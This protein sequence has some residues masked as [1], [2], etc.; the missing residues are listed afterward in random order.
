M[1]VNLITIILATVWGTY[2]NHK[3]LLDDPSSLL[4][5]DKFKPIFGTIP[6]TMNHVEIQEGDFSA[7]LAS[8]ITEVLRAKAKD[9]KTLEG[10]TQ[11]DSSSSESRGQCGLYCRPFSGGE[12][13]EDLNKNTYP[14]QVLKGKLSISPL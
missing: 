6:L 2:E 11:L 9:G 4:L 14:Y 7:A 10:L 1:D 3:T 8:S 13:R 5:G 12:V